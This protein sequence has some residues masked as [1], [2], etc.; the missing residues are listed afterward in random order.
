[1]F[2]IHLAIKILQLELAN[3]LILGDCRLKVWKVM[4]C[5][6]LMVCDIFGI[7]L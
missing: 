3:K 7:D 5:S 2:L 6:S 1:M 4:N